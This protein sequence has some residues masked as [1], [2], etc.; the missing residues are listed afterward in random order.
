MVIENQFLDSQN[1]QLINGP[2]QTD[3]TSD[4][5]SIDE[6]TVS[7]QESGDSSEFVCGRDKKDKKIKKSELK[8]TNKKLDRE[9]NIFPNIAKR[10]AKIIF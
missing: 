4:Y 5:E 6:N 8:K 7:D 1:P 2:S 3:H 9:K 10:T